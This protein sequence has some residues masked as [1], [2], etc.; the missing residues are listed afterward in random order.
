ME[1]FFLFFYL[2]TDIEKVLEKDLQG[3]KSKTKAYILIRIPQRSCYEMDLNMTSVRRTL[4]VVV[5]AAAATKPSTYL[6]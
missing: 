5:V 6:P 2:D 4:T 3:S 1:F